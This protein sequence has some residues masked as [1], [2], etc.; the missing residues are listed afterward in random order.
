LSATL[1]GRTSVEGV[2]RNV[3]G[4]NA[5]ERTAPSWAHAIADLTAALPDA[6]YL[7]AFRTRGDSLVVE[8]LAEQASDAFNAIEQIPTLANVRAGAPVRR[9]LQDD[10]TPLERFTIVAREVA[11]VSGRPGGSRVSGGARP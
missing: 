11:R 2:Y 10:A 5:I 9:E 8:G 4:L 3:A 6:A 1:I 7:T